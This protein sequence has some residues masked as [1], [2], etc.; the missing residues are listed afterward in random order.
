M[1]LKTE[2]GIMVR[3]NDTWLLHLGCDGPE[4]QAALSDLRQ[5]LL[6]TLR[7]TMAKRTL[8]N[9]AFLEDVV[10]DTLILVLERLHQFEGRSRFLTWAISIAIHVAMGRLRRKHW[11]NVSLEEI[12]GDS[13][14]RFEEFQ[15]DAFEPEIQW[16]RKSILESMHRVIQN[17]LT[18]KQKTALLAELKG[19]PQEEIVRHLGSNRNAVYKL[20]HD[21]RKRLKQGLEAAGYGAD[22][23]NSAFIT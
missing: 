16:E 19:M 12:I 4:Q 15:S 22:D 18:E 17:E 1:Y 3:N 8:V 21:A 11:K 13:S 9:E 5:A 7:R 20:T 10:Q 6:R 23:I 14:V 2:N